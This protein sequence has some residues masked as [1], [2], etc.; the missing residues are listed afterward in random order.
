MDGVDEVPPRLRSRTEQWL[1]GLIT[2]F[3]GARYV[4]TTRPSAVPEDWL[5]E[6]GF[7]THTLLPMGRDDIRAFV[8]HWHDAVRRECIADAERESLERLRRA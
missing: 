7:T 1:K 5:A 8:R 3:P 2:V 4:V 6:Q